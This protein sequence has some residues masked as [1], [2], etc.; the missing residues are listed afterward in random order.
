VIIILTLT[1]GIVATA[2]LISIIFH[3][4]IN[5]ELYLENNCTTTTKPIKRDLL[6]LSKEEQFKDGVAAIVDAFYY[7]KKKSSLEGGG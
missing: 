7:L 1:L 4:L 6:Y 2:T 3:L 5:Q